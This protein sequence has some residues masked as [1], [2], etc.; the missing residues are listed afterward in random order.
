MRKSLI[1]AFLFLTLAR[2]RVS[3][4]TTVKG[5]DYDGIV[6]ATGLSESCA[7]AYAARVSC[8]DHLFKLRDLEKGSKLFRTKELAQFCT[9]D[10]VDSLNE[11]DT[12]LQGSCDDRDKNFANSLGSGVYL[13]MALKDKH[14]VQ[15]NLYW[16]FCL[17]DEKSG[18]KN[19]FCL[20]KS[21]DLPAWPSNTA[22]NA[23][24]TA[25]I[26]DFCKSSCRTQQSYL[27]H[28][29][30]KHLGFSAIDLADAEKIC[31]GLD[32]ST[33]PV[34]IEMLDAF[35]SS[36]DPSPGRPDASK[37]AG[38]DAGQI[39]GT[40]YDWDFYKSDFGSGTAASLRV[41]S[42]FAFFVGVTAIIAI[43][44]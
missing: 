28:R 23:S 31:P 26:S 4:N 17:K 29:S 3:F 37:Q 2:A 27:M 16:S 9:Q 19:D 11:W 10:C 1:S 12:N 30:A 32:V 34:S 22:G 6:P 40:E 33:F 7:E 15:E 43:S 44:L 21:D 14:S 39:E 20:A 25:L 42:A 35:G 18:E 41:S 36:A 24:D 38:E 8:T 5:F 13:G